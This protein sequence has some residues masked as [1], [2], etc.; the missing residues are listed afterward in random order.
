MVQLQ[1]KRTELRRD[2]RI[3]GL[4]SIQGN[5]EEASI[6][7]LGFPSFICYVLHRFIF[8]HYVDNRAFAI[9]TANP[10]SYTDDWDN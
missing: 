5:D 8:I 4:S 3:N 10:E 1:Q 9:V 7:D 6:L 2:S